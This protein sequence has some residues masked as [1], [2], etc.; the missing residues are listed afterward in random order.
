MKQSNEKALSPVIGVI[1]MVAIT[2]ILAAV[3]AAFVFGMAG[4]IDHCDCKSCCS[5][6]YPCESIKTVNTTIASTD[7]GTPWTYHLIT[8][9]PLRYDIVVHGDGKAGDVY[10]EATDH[11]GE[12]ASI[13]YREY[14]S[15]C[16][17]VREI[18]SIS[19]E[20]KKCCCRCNS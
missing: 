4:K 7:W 6:I 9:E 8:T 14:T 15:N 3:I 10:R 16:K 5:D 13:T 19:Y 20:C 1:L 12:N 2:V 18:I 17:K 11:I